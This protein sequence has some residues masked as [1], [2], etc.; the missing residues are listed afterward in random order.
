MKVFF[1]NSYPESQSTLEQIQSF[2][3]VYFFMTSLL[4][5]ILLSVVYLRFLQE[6][7]TNI[8][9]GVNARLELGK[10]SEKEQMA[11]TKEHQKKI[12]FL[13][14]ECREVSSKFFYFKIV[15]SFSVLTPYIY[16]KNID[17]G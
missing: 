13:T 5:I 14:D 16:Y 15:P 11:L 2:Y 10:K 1:K 7:L 3:A 12:N 4:K 8:S 17:W 6:L 9:K